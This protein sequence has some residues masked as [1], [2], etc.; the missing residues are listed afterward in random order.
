[1][2][3]QQNQDTEIPTINDKAVVG[4]LVANP[5]FFNDRDD[6][7]AKMIVTHTTGASVSLIERQ[8]AILREQN[9]GYQ[10]QLAELVDVARVNDVL[11][12]KLQKLVL[13]LLETNELEPLLTLIQQSLKGDFNADG[14]TLCLFADPASLSL[15]S[16][17]IGDLQVRFISREDEQFKKMG[18][19][20]KGGEPA[21]GVLTD[22]ELAGLFDDAKERGIRSVAQLPLVMANKGDSTGVSLGVLAIGSKDA[23]RFCA[24]VGTV[25]LK[26]LGALV[27]RK[28]SPHLAAGEDV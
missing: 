23:G 27:T 12:V 8:V 28:L 24:G 25:F 15:E 3:V 11:M 7:L 19:L 26:Y 9:G 1:M 20:S 10:Q 16:D 13:A 6:L 21:C 18:N 5:E 17:Q 2:S 4:Y 14:V 22:A